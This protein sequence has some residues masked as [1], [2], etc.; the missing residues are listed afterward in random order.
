MKSLHNTCL[1]LQGPENWNLG[2]VPGQCT[3]SLQAFWQRK[4]DEVTVQ[5]IK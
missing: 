5:E 3:L 4:S 1:F 2:V